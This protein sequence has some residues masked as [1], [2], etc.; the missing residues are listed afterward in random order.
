MWGQLAQLAE[1]AQ[2]VQIATASMESTFE[3]VRYCARCTCGVRH[4]AT[5]QLRVEGAPGLVKSKAV[6]APAVQAISKGSWRLSPGTHLR[7]K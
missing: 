1:L 7:R 2:L 3:S 4:K 5:E 6:A